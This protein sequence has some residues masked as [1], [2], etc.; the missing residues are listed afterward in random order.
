MLYNN[1]NVIV[2]PAAGRVDLRAFAQRPLTAGTTWCRYTAYARVTALPYAR[3]TALPYG[4][5]EKRRCRGFSAARVPERHRLSRRI[6][7]STGGARAGETRP[8]AGIRSRYTHGKR[9]SWWSRALTSHPSKVK[10]LLVSSA[11]SP[12][13]PPHKS[14]VRRA[15]VRPHNGI[16]S[17]PTSRSSRA[18]FNLSNGSETYKRTCNK[19][20]QTDAIR[21]RARGARVA[22]KSVK[23]TVVARDYVINADARNRFDRLLAFTQSFRRRRIPRQ[24]IKTLDVFKDRSGG[25]GDEGAKI[26]TADNA[27]FIIM[28]MSN[29]GLNVFWKEQQT[30]KIL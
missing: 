19:R 11:R 20:Q 21:A 29:N 30:R 16:I 3:V 22:K 15:T 17:N 5:M 18:Y 26:H 4:R 13:R 7:T 12:A 9:L 25:G 8:R 24:I 23:L 28:T 2:L 10:I 27:N 14:C 1:D 6:M